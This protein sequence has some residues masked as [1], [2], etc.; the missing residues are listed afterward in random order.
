MAGHPNR[1]ANNYLFEIFLIGA[2]LKSQPDD[3]LACDQ[4]RGAGCSH[5]VE[6]RDAFPVQ[7]WF[8]TADPDSQNDRAV[9]D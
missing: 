5:L 8:A 6:E 2:V 3:F 1:V 4:V 7:I 9:V